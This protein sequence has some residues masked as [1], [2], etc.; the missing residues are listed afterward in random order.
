LTDKALPPEVL[1]VEPEHFTCRRN[2]VIWTTILAMLEE[3]QPHDPVSVFARMSLDGGVEAGLSAYLLDLEDAAVTAVNLGYWARQLADIGER[4]LLAHRLQS[5][6]A[7]DCGTEEVIARVDEAMATSRRARGSAGGLCHVKEPLRGLLAELEAE[8]ANPDG[9]RIARTGIPDLDDKLE[10][11]A[12]DLT[13]IA[14]RPSMGKSALAGNIASECARDVTRGATCLFS[15]EMSAV[16]LVRRMVAGR[17]RVPSRQMV[18]KIGDPVLMDAIDKT[19][20]LDL[21]IDD[22]AGIGVSQIRQSL[23]RLPRVRMVVVDYLQLVATSADIERHDLRVGAI[24]KAL[25]AIAKDLGCHV[26]AL[27]Q[28][29]RRVEERRPPR[30]QVSDLRDSGN[31]EEDADNVLMLYRPAYYDAR[32][33]ETEA[34]IIIG[35]Q[36]NG[37]TGAVTVGWSSDRQMFYSRAR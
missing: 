34:E 33:D 5:T 24:T 3:R 31:I 32:A 29:N 7:E 19:H 16:S 18:H 2:A 25:K 30:P 21:W 12:G 11:R 36:R 15:L 13:I 10:L 28:L 17:A 8:Y 14:G 23:M 1:M 9:H 26:I 22:R 35:K 27:S 37:P 4:R 20:H 6:L